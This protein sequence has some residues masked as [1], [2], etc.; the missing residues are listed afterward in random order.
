MRS[1]LRDRRRRR[2]KG[3]PTRYDDPLIMRERLYGWTWTA[4]ASDSAN[5]ERGRL[6]AALA[7][8]STRL[9]VKGRLNSGAV[10]IFRDSV[11]KGLVI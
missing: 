7:Q 4:T 9:R 10:R 5:Y 2:R 3:Y 6:W 1:L 11:E 8:R